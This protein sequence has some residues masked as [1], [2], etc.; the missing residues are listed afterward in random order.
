MKHA[1]RSRL[2]AQRARSYFVRL[3]LAV[4]DVRVAHS[5]A[6]RTPYEMRL[7]REGGRVTA[8]Y[9]LSMFRHGSYQ[10]KHLSAAYWYWFAQ[11]GDV[12][13]ALCD[14]SDG[15]RAGRARFA[16]SSNRDA[17][18]AL[19]DAYF[20]RDR[21]F[22]DA[23][24]LG[25]QAPAWQD[26]SEEILGRGS[27]NGIGLFTCDPANARTPGVMQRMRLAMLSRDIDG[28]DV[29]FAPGS[30]DYVDA[31]LDAAG[32]IGPKVPQD[33]WAGRKFAID[34]D[35]VTNTW[36]NFLRRLK[37]GCC[38]LKVASPFGFAQWYYPLLRPFEHYVPIR[39][40]LS[41]LAEQIDWVRAH[42][43]KAA[44]IAE[45]GQAAARALTFETET[46]RA[47]ELMTTHA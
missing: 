43:A 14:L 5:S 6:L 11:A 10:M 22:A 8:L 16:Y 30:R 26:R 38:V 19:P 41:D 2:I 9:N 24:R 39:A 35:G 37:M 25:Q 17:V 42:P 29:R 33:S 31:E 21:G 12:R 40:D 1:V 36:D 32:L 23:D 13:A 20:F 46:A 18:I 4:P 28:V 44:Q 15:E 47:V 27:A 3:G 45:A 7:S 34:I